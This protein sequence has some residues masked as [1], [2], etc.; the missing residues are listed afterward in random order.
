MLGV[1]FNFKLNYEIFVFLEQIASERG[2]NPSHGSSS[3]AGV[4]LHKQVAGLR[5][6]HSRPG[7]CLLD[8]RLKRVLCKMNVEGTLHTRLPSTNISIDLAALL[9]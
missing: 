8:G 1:S 5:S 9:A 4:A 7:A 2:I 6:A 3:P